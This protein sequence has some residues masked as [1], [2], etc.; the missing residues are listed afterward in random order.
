MPLV[1]RTHYLALHFLHV[2]VDANT[3]LK[4]SSFCRASKP[5]SWVDIFNQHGVRFAT[6]ALP[7]LP[8]AGGVLGHKEQRVVDV[9]QFP[10][11]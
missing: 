9:G 5:W 4:L 11:L 7:Q 6:V 2:L 3:F 1:E 10:G 8:S